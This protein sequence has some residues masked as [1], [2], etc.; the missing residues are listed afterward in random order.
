MR[1][2]TDIAWLYTYLEPKETFLGDIQ[3]K[4]ENI[5][6]E[7]LMAFSTSIA[8][9]AECDESPRHSFCCPRGE[10]KQAYI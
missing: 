10:N 6:A 7:N 9:A 1:F 8:V 2:H 4:G 3:L 5:S